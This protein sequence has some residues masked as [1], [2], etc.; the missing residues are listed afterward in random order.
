MTQDT[1]DADGGSPTTGMTYADSGVDY[2]SI[3]PAK[4]LAQRAAAATATEISRFGFQEVGA[5][6]GES[7]YVWEEPDA[8]RVLV[9]ECLGTKCLVADEMR[10]VTGRS[11][12][13]AIAQDTVAMIVNDVAA[14]GAQPLV[15]NAYWAIGDSDWFEDRVRAADLVRGWAEACRAAG[16]VWGGGETPALTGVIERGSIDLAGA[17][18]GIVRPKSRLT[19]GERL[20]AGDSVVLLASSGIHANGLTLARSIAAALPDGYATDIGDGTMYGEALL[21]PTLVYPRLLADLFDAGIDVHYMSN[22]TGHG[23]RK[24]MRAR[25]ELRYVMTEVPPLT[26][27]FGFLVEHGGLSDE[28]AY[29]TLNMGAGFAVFV[30]E[31]DARSVVDVGRRH[32]VDAWIAGRTE[33]GRRSVVIEPLGIT[34]EGASLSVRQ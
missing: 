2:E 31:G 18:T 22:L 34:Y 4:V 1:P 8:Y 29:G 17:C 14:V 16:A 30:P 6:R 5:S 9:M 26:P 33:E 15:V 21:A 28:E 32:G 23:W 27:L 10:S 25:K 12:Y 3:D 7:A 19:L 13:D 24:I 20:V 11:Y